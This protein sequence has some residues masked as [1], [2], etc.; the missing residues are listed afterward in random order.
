MSINITEN[1]SI[2]RDP[3][4]DNIEVLVMVE[5]SDYVWKT[6]IKISDWPDYL[7]YGYNGRANQADTKGRF[8]STLEYLKLQNW[9]WTITDKKHPSTYYI[10]S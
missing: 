9:T 6:D 8:R 3:E 4:T 5:G 2:N 7:Y 10:D 1:L